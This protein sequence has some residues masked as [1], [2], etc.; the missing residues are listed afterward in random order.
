MVKY[1]LEI[2]FV[3]TE[4]DVRRFIYRIRF[5]LLLVLICLSGYL[6]ACLFGGTYTF[7]KSLENIGISGDAYELS[8]HPETDGKLEITDHHI[9]NGKLVMELKAVEEGYIGICITSGED[10]A[11]EHFYVHWNGIITYD[12]YF[13]DYTGSILVQSLLILYTVIMILYLICKFIASMKK[14]IYQYRN[15]LYVGII[16]FAVFILFAECISLA[17]DRGL[18]NLLIEI[19]GAFELQVR[20]TS[21]VVVIVAVLVAVSNITLMRREG[22]TWRNML[23]IFLGILVCAGIV[24]PMLPEGFVS[25]ALRIENREVRAAVGLGLLFA[26]DLLY[27]VTAYLEELLIG[28]VVIGLVAAKHK[29]KPDKDYIIILGCQIRKDGTLP[30][31]LRSRVDKAL[32]LARKQEE[33]NSH[34]AVFVPSGGQGSDE[35]IAEAEAIKN[36]LV[37]QGIEESRIIVEDRSTSTEENFKLSY[38]LI[39]KD[40]KDRDPKIAFSTTNYHV[41]RSGIIANDAGIKA[42]GAGSKTKAYFWINAFVREFI[43][44]LVSEWKTHLH[45]TG[46]L[47]FTCVLAFV[48]YYV[49]N[50]VLS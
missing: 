45:V 23:A 14:S 25:S 42:E 8:L 20:L 19:E 13:G 9:E 38:E 48:L 37:E 24:I 36:Y 21:P 30:N 34:K 16:I 27:S 41:L 28:T 6:Y 22:I 26:G 2:S 11:T 46:Y 7:S 31:L 29:P 47:T 32:E 35:V 12:S 49:T 3:N 43:A 15:V 10:K 33:L 1:I 4:P 39:K 50:V 40:C 18:I 5:L 44:T 17:I